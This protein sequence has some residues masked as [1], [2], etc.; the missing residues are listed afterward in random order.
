MKKN[1]CHHAVLRCLQIHV[2]SYCCSVPLHVTSV[3]VR[4]RQK[5]SDDLY[6]QAVLWKECSPYSCCWE[7]QSLTPLSSTPTSGH[8]Q[9]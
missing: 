8:C 1:H 6:Q 4:G 7:T 9:I 2:D 3:G 5:D